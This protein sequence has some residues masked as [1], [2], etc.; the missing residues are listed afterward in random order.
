MKSIKTLDI[1]K[2]LP[3]DATLKADILENYLDKMDQTTKTVINDMAWKAYDHL[4][5]I[6]LEENI[7]LGMED[8]K[9]G[10]DTLGNNFSGRMRVKTRQQMEHWIFESGKDER[11]IELVREKLKNILSFSPKVSS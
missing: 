5:S 2:A 11:E 3:I 7:A 9:N 1:I 4:F 10:K 6:Q 8:V